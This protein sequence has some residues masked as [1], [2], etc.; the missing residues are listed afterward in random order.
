MAE[1]HPVQ[2]FRVVLEKA[3]L[4]LIEQLA[5]SSSPLT[6]SNFQLL[7]TIQTALSAVREEI[8]AHGVGWGGQDTLE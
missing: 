8:R 1:Q 3:R 2:A 5:K 7:A 6:E 4:D